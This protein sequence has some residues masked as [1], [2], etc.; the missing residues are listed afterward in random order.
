MI[1]AII[2]AACV[3]ILIIGWLWFFIVRPVLEHFDVIR[4]DDDR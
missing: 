3:I 2:F 4:D 1:Q